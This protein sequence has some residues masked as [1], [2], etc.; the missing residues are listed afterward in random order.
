MIRI[1]IDAICVIVEI[2]LARYLFQAFL[3]ECRLDKRKE[4]I[5]ALQ[6]CI[7]R[8]NTY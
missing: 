1:A 5:S 7:I 3:G 8:G 2:L 6:K 4:C